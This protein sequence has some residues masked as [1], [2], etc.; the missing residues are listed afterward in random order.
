MAHKLFREVVIFDEAHSVLDTIRDNAAKV[1]W[2]RQYKFPRTLRTYS[3]LL[4]WTSKHPERNAAGTRVNLLH[5]ELTSGK[6]RY[7]AQKTT[8]LYRGH[9]EECIKLLPID[10][11]DQP[12]FLWPSPKVKKLVLLSATIGRV[13]IEQ[14]GLAKRRVRIIQAGSPIPISRRPIQYEPIANMSFKNWEESVPAFCDYL[15][16]KL[17]AHSGQAGLVHLSYSL[18]AAVRAKMGGT[19]N[20]LLFHGQDDK[21]R[22]YRR[23][24]EEGPAKGLVLVASGM[25]EGISLDG[26]AGSW[27]VI[28]KVPYP[29]LAE[30]AIAWQ[31]EQDPEGYAWGAIKLLAQASGR[32]CRSPED[33]GVTYV[34]DAAFARLYQ[35]Y[36]ELF[37]VWFRE[38]VVGA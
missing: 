10:V 18:A 24:R 30:P 37:P 20:R 9:E 15:R 33:F 27:Q 38:A 32:I 31:A 5:R 21:E 8:D 34:A 2:H 3:D 6:A 12:P 19:D 28:G 1:L 13:D 14:M 16:Q 23:F 11:S 35:D 22:Q 17:E 26:D 36:Q 25:Y 29:S 7:L 4:A